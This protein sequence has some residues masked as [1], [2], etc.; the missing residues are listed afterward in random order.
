MTDFTPNP[1]DTV[2]PSFTP[3]PADIIG[4]VEEAPKKNFKE[5]FTEDL[6]K[7]GQMFKEIVL[8]D[9]DDD[10]TYAESVFQVTTKVGIGAMFDF[11]GEV[12]VSGGRGLQAITPD[13]V[14]GF[15]GNVATKA[16]IEFL[17][18]SVGR[19][20]LF[21]A[22]NGAE[23]YQEFAEEHPRAARNVEGVTN[24]GLLMAPVKAK[25]GSQGLIGKA[26]TELKKSGIRAVGKQK[27]AFVKD[28]VTPKQTAAVKTEQVAR[29]A[30]RGIGPFK[31]SI[32]KLTP[33]QEAAAKE[34]MKT[35]V[36]PRNTIQGNYNVIKK[37]VFKETD[38]LA[39]QLSKTGARGRFNKQEFFDE[40]DD[41]FLRLQKNHEIVGVS[42]VSAKRIVAIMREMAENEKTHVSGLLR[43]RKNFDRKFIDEGRSRA[44]DPKMENAMSI[45]LREIR[46]TT[47]DFIEQR[48]PQVG[49]KNSLNKQSKLLS[50]MDDIAPKAA[51]EANTAIARQIQNAVKLLTV[52]GELNQTAALLFGMGGLGASARFAPF[53]TKL[54]ALSAVTYMAG[55]TVMR[56]GTRKGLGKL[57]KL[58]D[59][60]T[61][62][63]SDPAVLQQ[64]R[65]DRALIVEL[66]K[67]SEEE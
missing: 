67:N 53:I 42:E 19:G 63:V 7:R 16:G 22:Q 61:L 10:Q 54:G 62:K 49:V 11:L 34:V 33:L 25:P 59:K 12:M 14:E 64:A 31:T 35:A 43:A 65:A 8:A 60:M 28:L 32:V 30:E 66:L 23:S 36:S 50:A 46:Q 3:N 48:A 27:G 2:V 39:K 47:N 51:A 1:N 18:T 40:L 41:A 38:L 6:E 29:T 37:A 21:A 52:R 55:R 5:R 17:K 9:M 4:S 15:V 45:T 44:F 20:A 57:L 13:P 58:M 56:P 24:L 26:G